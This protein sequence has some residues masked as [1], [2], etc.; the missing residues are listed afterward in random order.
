MR[1]TL[2]ALAL[3]LALS[4]FTACESGNPQP[5][6]ECAS[7]SDCKAVDDYCSTCSCVALKSDA[8]TPSCDSPTC[9]TILP[10]CHDGRAACVSGKCEIVRK[11]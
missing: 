4:L 5:A 8:P 2:T 9:V 7:D 6:S 1:R 10:L 11:P 3:A